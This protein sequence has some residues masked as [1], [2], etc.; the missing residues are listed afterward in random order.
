LIAFCVMIALSSCVTV[1]YPVRLAY[2]DDIRNW[3][4]PESIAAGLGVPGFAN[5]TIYNYIVLAF[6]LTK[7]PAD[8]VLVWSD[9]IKYFGASS[10]FGKTKQ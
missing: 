6:W 2:I 5:K 8:C 1:D 3:W 7:G 10:Q 9:P 4:P